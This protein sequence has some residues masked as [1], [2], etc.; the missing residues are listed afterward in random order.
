M[1]PSDAKSCILAAYDARDL[2]RIVKI[3]KS[4]QWSGTHMATVVWLAR[5]T[6][7]DSKCCDYILKF[8]ENGIRMNIPTPMDFVKKLRDGKYIDVEY[9][10]QPFQ[11]I[12]EYKTAL[13]YGAMLRDLDAAAQFENNGTR[14]GE[15]A[16]FSLVE[17]VNDCKFQE[18]VVSL[19]VKHGAK[20]FPEDCSYIYMA[21]CSVDTASLLYHAGFKHLQA[22]SSILNDGCAATL[23]FL[24][25]IGA[26]N[27]STENGLIAANEIVKYMT[28]GQLAYNP[29]IMK[30]IAMHV[31]SRDVFNL[32]LW[33]PCN[34]DD[35]KAAIQALCDTWMK[36]DIFVFSHATLADD[37][38]ALYLKEVVYLPPIDLFCMAWRGMYQSVDAYL[39]RRPQQVILPYPFFKSLAHYHV[40]KKHKLEIPEDIQQHYQQH[41]LSLNRKVPTVIASKILEM[42]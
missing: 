1:C 39:V 16:I 17:T 11:T 2:D 12:D 18:A 40:A 35:Q 3:C 9:T 32:I 20:K 6:P 30:H 21:S 4:Q 23:E 41:V 14:S 8:V 25:A 10:H 33:H 37:S 36:L 22:T 38:I 15:S 24:L 26:L 29:A 13:E 31:K 34:S 42:C 7:M 27:P 28:N 19:L 5:N